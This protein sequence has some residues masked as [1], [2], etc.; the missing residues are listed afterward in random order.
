MPRDIPHH[1]DRGPGSKRSWDRMTSALDV[2]VLQVHCSTSP[3][4]APRLEFSNS[5]PG[6]P[7]TAPT[8]LPDSTASVTALNGSEAFQIIE[9]ENINTSR[10]SSY[11]ESDTPLRTQGSAWTQ[12]LAS[13]LINLNVYGLVNAFGVF[14]NFYETQYLSSYSSSAISWI[15]TVQGSLVLIIGAL[16]GPMFDKGYFRVALRVSSAVLVFSWMML[17]LSS[18]YYQVCLP[19]RHL[20][21]KSVRTCTNP[22]KIMLTQGVLAGV[23]VGLLEIPSIALIPVY[24]DKRLGL[25]L[26]LA[27]SGAPTGGLIYS[28]IFRALLDSIGFG[29]A[30][31]IVGFIVFVTLGIA[32]VIIR[33]QDAVRKSTRK[34]LDLSAFRESDFICLF[35]TAYFTYCAA[36]VPYFVTPAYAL[37]LGSSSTMATYLL[38]ILNVA[39]IFGRI[40]PAWLSDYIGGA[41]MLLIAIAVMGVMGL[42]WIGATTIPGFIAFLVFYGIVSGAVATL[43]ATVIP[44][45]C[46]S[47]ETLG[48]R[49]G[50]VYAAAGVGTLVGNPIALATAG[51]AL[52]REQFL[53]AQLWMGLCALAG[54]AFFII[55]AR[56]ASRN[57]AT[58]RAGSE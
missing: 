9:H 24:F 53:G 33:P 47:P 40:V 27:I 16:A 26:G 3:G 51:H 29:W 39:Q 30:T 32:V 44:Y 58:L 17:S 38:A 14:Q 52:R 43:P 37:S 55:P 2:P 34:F 41:Y 36:L 49:I 45:I 1:G 28:L 50:M 7:C 13:F 4:T 19:Q 48:T 35:L 21:A 18:Q 12:V 31:R 56:S 11:S 15:G 20:A 5:H 8:P 10:R 22:A 25:A 54:S 42:A 6:V 57:R 23:C 46:P